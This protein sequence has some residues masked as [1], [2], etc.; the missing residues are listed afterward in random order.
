MI[1]NTES[2]RRGIHE[3]AYTVMDIM[4]FALDYVTPGITTRE[5][6]EHINTYIEM[7]DAESAPKVF[8]DFPSYTCISINE[9]VAHGV[10]GNRVILQEDLVKIDISIRDRNG[11]CADMC[12]TVYFGHDPVRQHLVNVAK[13]CVHTV[14]GN[15]KAGDS[16]N[17]IGQ[18]IDEVA[19]KNRVFVEERLTGHGIGRHI[20]E[21]PTIPNTFNLSKLLPAHELSPGEV[22]CIE[23]IIFQ[24]RT[25]VH[26]N[27]YVYVSE[28]GAHAAQYE[29]MVIVTED[30]TDNLT[31]DIQWNM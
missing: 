13:Q 28:T 10:A 20:H 22:I 19:F 25:S 11:Y 23:P 1:I 9:E 30:G 14:I 24:S 3:A 29:D 12:R 27:E 4:A 6:D 15:L 31:G 2:E 18:I 5:L 17:K 16:V 8:Y 7:S 26:M 21:S